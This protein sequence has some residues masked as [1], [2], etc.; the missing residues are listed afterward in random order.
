MFKACLVPE[1]I[2]GLHPVRINELLYQKLPFKAKVNDQRLRGTNT[3]LARGAGPVV[4][5]FQ[6]LCRLETLLQSDK[7]KFKIE[8]GKIICDDFTADFSDMRMKVGASLKLLTAA[9][10]LQLFR[11][12]QA[13]KPF[14]D[15]KFHHLLKDS[16]PITDELLGPNLEQKIADHSKVFEVAKKLTPFR[17]QNF[18]RSRGFRNTRSWVRRRGSGRRPF[19]KNRSRFEDYRH[20]RSPSFNCGRYN[21]RNFRQSRRPSS[22][23]RFNNRH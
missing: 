15:R 2:S 23:A 17:Q 9:H 1:N 8:S 19:Y 4:N 10:A 5:V 7:N 13:L 16:N 22:R 20:D 6:D 14:L 21:N 3:F 11:R 18:T 12:R